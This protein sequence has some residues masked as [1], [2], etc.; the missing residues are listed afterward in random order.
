[1][2]FGLDST[3]GDLIV[4]GG[5]TT[6]TGSDELSQRIKVGIT[7]N[8]GEFFTHINYGLP[9]IQN[10]DLGTIDVQYFLGENDNTTVQ[11]VVNALD[12]YLLSIE[13]VTEVTSTYD[14]DYT[15]RT[16]TYEPS[17]TGED[18]DTVD[19]PPYTLEI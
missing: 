18:S 3:T 2:D 5:M 8:I 4:D 19:F 17:I 11:Y 12:N 14:F 6:V 16:L 10:P 9:W 1:M 15:T 7:I 13:Q